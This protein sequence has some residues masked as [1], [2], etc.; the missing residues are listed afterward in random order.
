MF[1]P[2]FIS[3]TA[4]ETS[5]S[6]TGNKVVFHKDN[7]PGDNISFDQHVAQGITYTDTDGRFTVDK[8]G[9]YEVSCTAVL[10]GHSTGCDLQLYVNDSEE[11]QI[12]T[13]V[14]ISVDP[15]ERTIH[16][17]FTVAD[18]GYFRILVNDSTG[19]TVNT[20]TTIN[21]KRIA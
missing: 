18:G 2:A 4:T 5:D 14:H 11:V 15:V 21:I 17:I 10:N 8:A 1:A 3:V 9:T 19:G 13:Q 12:S 6:M 20:G 7:Y 16:G